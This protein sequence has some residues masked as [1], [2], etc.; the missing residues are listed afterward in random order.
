MK[1]SVLIIAIVALF[2]SANA[3]SEIRS[4]RCGQDFVKIKDDKYSVMDKCG[5]AKY[6]EVVSG[7]YGRKEERLVYKFNQDGPL[8]V[9]SFYAGKLYKIEEIRR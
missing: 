1:T 6:T 9:F 3:N 2:I 8:T 7:A 4:K 5:S